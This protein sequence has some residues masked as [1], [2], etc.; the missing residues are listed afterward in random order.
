[1]SAQTD[2]GTKDFGDSGTTYDKQADALENTMGG[3]ELRCLFGGTS[4]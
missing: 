1:M 3:R 4:G 2:P